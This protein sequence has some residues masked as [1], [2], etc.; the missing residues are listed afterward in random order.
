MKFN[1]CNHFKSICLNLV[2]LQRFAL[3]RAEA[4]VSCALAARLSKEYFVTNAALTFLAA[5]VSSA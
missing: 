4:D 1:D 5:S 2:C 3:D